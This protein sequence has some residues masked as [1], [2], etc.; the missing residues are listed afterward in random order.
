MRSLL[1][2]FTRFLV[3]D[4]ISSSL[5][6]MY[7]QGKTISL[8]KLQAEKIVNADDFFQNICMQHFHETYTTKSK[9]YVL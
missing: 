7:K 8:L 4:D 1:R 3:I 5:K 9:K 6:K 2:G